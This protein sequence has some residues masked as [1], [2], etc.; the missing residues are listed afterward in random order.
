MRSTRF[1]VS[2]IRRSS[3]STTLRS[4]IPFSIR[5]CSRSPRMPISKNSDQRPMPTNDQ[6]ARLEQWLAAEGFPLSDL[7]AVQA[8]ETTALMRA[9]RLGRAD[10]VALL[11]EQGVDVNC[12]NADQ[13]P[14]L[15]F[16]CFSDSLP[17]IELLINAGA[18]LNNQNVN[19]A[20]P[21]IFAASAG[22]TEV[23]Q[24]LL[25]HGA[26]TTPETLDGFA[27]L[28]SAATRP[29]LKLLRAAATNETQPESTP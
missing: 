29:I 13:N 5:D 14:A 10:I 24:L 28:D 11:I 26:S 15:W 17:S 21:L 4:A 8:N 22:K 20:T 25:Q 19:G 18:N 6:P 23:V 9:A 3:V 12:L 16:A 27:A 1:S 2:M 7:E